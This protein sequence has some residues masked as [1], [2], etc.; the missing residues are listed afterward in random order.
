MT[1][2]HCDIETRSSVDL[3]ATNTYR[4]VEDPQFE[5]LAAAWAVN[6][7]PIFRT[8]GHQESTKAFVRLSKGATVTAH[9]ANFE[10]I[11]FSAALGM[12]IG[13]YLDPRGFECTMALA[14][15]HGLPR[16]LKNLGQFVGGEEK[17]EA[18]TLLIKFFCVPKKDGTFNQPEDNPEK[19]AQFM[20]YM[21]Q[22]VATHRDAHS[23]IMRQGGWPT[24]AERNVWICDQL[25][26]DRGL[27][28]NEPLAEKAKVAAE[29]NAIDQK[30]RI[31][32]LTGVDNPG[33]VPQMMRWVADEVIDCP[34]MQ[35]K[36][37]ERLLERGVDDA[38]ALE[39][40]QREVLELRTELAMASSKKFGSALASVGS[41]SRL[42]GAIKYHGAHTGRWAGK[43]TQPHN[44]PGAS[45]VDDLDFAGNEI[46][47]SG[48]MNQEMMIVDL[49]NGERIDA[50]DL[51]RLVRPMF[52]GPFTI[53]DYKSIE[54]RVIAGLAGEAWALKAFLEGRDL[55]VET[56]KRMGPK[57][58]RKEGKIA[59]LALGFAGGL[60]SLRAMGG[61]G[62]DGELRQIVNQW[63]RANPRIVNLWA[64]LGDAFD[65]ASGG[66][67]VGK[68][69][70]VTHS[71]N[72]NGKSVHIHLPSGRVLNYHNVKWERYAVIDPKTGK[73]KMKESFRYADPGNPFNHRLRI[74][75]YGGRLTENVVQATARDILANGLVN[76][77]KAGY[78]VVAHVHDE[79]LIEGTHDLALIN[80]IVC[81]LP[82]WAQGWL[83]IDGDGGH[84]ERYR[85]M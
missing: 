28:I 74:G 83:P 82:E 36:T 16:S 32:E 5:I 45:F 62:T 77:E 60:G 23:Y 37:I 73:R 14:A 20:A 53:I 15:L 75:T 55:Y 24:R 79:F 57:Y 17:D 41:D 76:L 1:Y 65:P 19:W 40:H 4:Y 18:G 11:C 42:R 9:N 30:K 21:E 78:R 33:S 26:N 39:P 56:A 80:K 50:M 43:G 61:E 70:M 38:G 29:L 48:L 13:E 25:I 51:K 22:D 63:R 49:M 35:A 66:G 64:Q 2:V 10:R 59:V 71:T 34:N 69:L 67:R 68:H 84:T 3:R 7:E 58:T 31:T 81:D 8:E 47:G 27:L 52:H 85:K 54:A 12:P 6:D 72:R 46:E 44:L